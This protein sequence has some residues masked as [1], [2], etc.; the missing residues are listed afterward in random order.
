MRGSISPRVPLILTPKARNIPNNYT[1]E[2][3]L[4]LLDRHGFAGRYDF[5][6]LPCDFYRDANLGHPVF[7]EMIFGFY[8]T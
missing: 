7:P 2:M 3:F 6:Y 4:E 5:A 1:R 8:T